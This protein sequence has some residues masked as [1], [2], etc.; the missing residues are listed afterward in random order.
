MRINPWK[1]HIY[2]CLSEKKM[3]FGEEL[4]GDKGILA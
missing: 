4:I 2:I 3:I 1:V